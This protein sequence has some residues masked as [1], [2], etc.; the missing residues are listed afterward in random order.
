MSVDDS[1]YKTRIPSSFS[2]SQTQDKEFLPLG[3]KGL[4]CFLSLTMKYM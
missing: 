4:V 2:C 3:M 1:L